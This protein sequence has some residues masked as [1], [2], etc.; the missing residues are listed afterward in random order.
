M[1]RLAKCVAVISAAR[2]AVAELNRFGEISSQSTIVP[3]SLRRGP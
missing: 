1:Q 2:R 3:E